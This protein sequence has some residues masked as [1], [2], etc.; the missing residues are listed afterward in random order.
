MSE[1]RYLLVP[2]EGPL[3]ILRPGTESYDTLNKAVGG[4]IECVPLKVNEV[5]LWLH[6]E[7]KIIGLPH[8]PRAQLLWEH[9]YGPSDVIVG[10]AVLTGGVDDEGE[11]LGLTLSEMMALAG[12]TLQEPIG[13][14]AYAD[15]LAEFDKES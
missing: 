2:I 9:S 10:P 14:Q 1:A 5:S 8:N 7:G 11:T 13:A 15:L 6:E 4:Y 12:I 3:Q